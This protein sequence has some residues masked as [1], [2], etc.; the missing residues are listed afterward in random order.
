MIHFQ[1]TFLSKNKYEFKQYLRYFIHKIIMSENDP[2][3]L[4]LLLL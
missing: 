4:S 1:Q 2:A 3:N